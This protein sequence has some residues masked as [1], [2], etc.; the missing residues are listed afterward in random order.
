MYYTEDEARQ[1]ILKAGLKLIEEK[2]IARTWGN[3]SARISDDEFIITP[4]GKAY[5]DLLPNDLV[6]VKISDLSYEGNIKPSSEKGIHAS[7]Y[8]LRSDVNFVIHTH[9]NYATAI[10]IEGE[11]AFA[12]TAKYGLPGTKKLRKNVYDVIL[13]NN[14]SSCFLLERHGA[15]ILGSSF[16]DCFDK[17]R[18]LEAKAKEVFDNNHHEID[19]NNIKPYLDDYAQM[20][21]KGSTAVEE[22][23]DAIELIKFK[24][25][26]AAMYANKAKPMKDFDIALQHFVYK[27]KY[28]KLKDKK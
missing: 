21:G 3:I 15:L 12:P 8:A 22:D 14:E 28:S 23:A 27:K 16:E 11:H 17:A 18:M 4:S 25:S 5:N 10:S 2:L 26:L 24:N 9:Q 20:F 6:K 13:K 7:S 19:I 1:L